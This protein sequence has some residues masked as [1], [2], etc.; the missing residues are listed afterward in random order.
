MPAKFRCDAAYRETPSGSFDSSLIEKSIT[1]GVLTSTVYGPGA[2]L[3]RF[4]SDSG[5]ALVGSSL[6]GVSGGESLHRSRDDSAFPGSAAG[7]GPGGQSQKAG[8]T[9]LRLIELPD[10]S[11]CRRQTSSTSS[12]RQTEQAGRTKWMSGQ[13]VTTPESDGA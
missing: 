5:G 7:S 11:D 6:L 13:V 3:V 1:N 2:G 10:C 12:T 4:L 8:L 9:G